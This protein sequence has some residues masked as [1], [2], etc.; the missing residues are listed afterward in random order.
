[1]KTLVIPDIHNKVDAVDPIIDKHNPDRVVLLGDYFDSFEERPE[2]EEKIAEHTALW[3]K[4]MDHRGYN[5]FWGNHEMSYI[6]PYLYRCSGFTVEKYDIINS[7]ITCDIWNR[8]KLV[9]EIDG[10]WLSH[11]GMHNSIF[12]HPHKGFTPEDVEAICNAAL[13]NARLRVPH[14]ALEAGATRG[15]RAPVGGITWLDWQNMMPFWDK[16]GNPIRQLVGHTPGKNVRTRGGTPEEFHCAC[17][18]THLTYVA[19]I[20]DGHVEFHKVI[21]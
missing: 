9:M 3:V 12:S 19:T 21:S 8:F 4:E 7:I 2:T 16:E 14:P 11:A 5:I 17:M 10:I 13:E 15:G 18:D 20:V 1:M 6:F